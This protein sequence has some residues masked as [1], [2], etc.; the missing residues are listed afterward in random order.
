M[1]LL[2]EFF[3]LN[4]CLTVYSSSSGFR[5]TDSCILVDINLYFP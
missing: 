2:G 3:Y 1:L 4:T 5:P